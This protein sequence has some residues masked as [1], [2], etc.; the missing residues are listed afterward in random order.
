MPTTLRRLCRRVLEGPAE[1]SSDLFKC[2]RH[3]R[4]QNVGG[5]TPTS[6]YC[7]VFC[8]GGGWKGNSG[9]FSR[10]RVSAMVLASEMILEAS[11]PDASSR[12]LVLLLR[13][14]P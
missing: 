11:G 6:K 10:I 8:G 7:L 9:N 5:V 14:P 4:T 12:I 13:R 1:E 3:D 2:Y